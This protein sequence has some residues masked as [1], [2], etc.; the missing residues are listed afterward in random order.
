MAPSSLARSAPS[1][2]CDGQVPV[3]MICNELPSFQLHLRPCAKHRIA[4]HDWGECCVEARV[5]RAQSD[6]LC[7][8]TQNRRT[9]NPWADPSVCILDTACRVPRVYVQCYVERPPNLATW[10]G[11]HWCMYFCSFVLPRV[12]LQ[13][14]PRGH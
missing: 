2:A 7:G 3:L 6:N 12:V 1:T 14:D 5:Q 11:K 8:W 9:D 4:Q 10:R 13:L